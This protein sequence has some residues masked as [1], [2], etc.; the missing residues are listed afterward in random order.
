[1]PTSQF[2]GRRTRPLSRHNALVLTRRRFGLALA[3]AA[4]A[5]A[6]PA[7]AQPADLAGW[8]ET[9][10]GMS[11]DELARVLG[12]R[13][14][15]LAA[16]LDYNQLVVRDTVPGLRLAGRPFVA[17]LQLDR[18]TERLAQVL[19]RYRG[20]F[21]MLSDFVAVRDLLAKD[22]GAPAER[23]AETDYRGSI[24]SFWIE[25][26]WT[27]PSTA[28]VLALVDQN[29]DPYSGQRKTLTVRYTG[30]RAAP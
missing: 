16:P 6:A 8:G 9:R 27:F 22:L 25:A 19:L 28:V 4:A 24:P 2:F 21:P 13:R 7:A 14:A 30:R 23:R 18:Q 12:S 3:A 15:H 26:G 1:M 20:D 11:R 17:L 10:W 29:A 5:P